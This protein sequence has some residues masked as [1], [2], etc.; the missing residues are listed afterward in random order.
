MYAIPGD[1]DGFTLRLSAID[2]SGPMARGVAA[3]LALLTAYGLWSAPGVLSQ[4]GPVGVTGIAIA[5]LWVLAASLALIIARVRLRWSGLAA[6]TVLVVALRLYPL[7][8]VEGRVPDGDAAIYPALAQS[9]LAGHGLGVIDPSLEVRVWAYYPP[10]FP[11][12]LAGW[13]AIAGFSARS[14]LVFNLIVDTVAALMILRIAERLGMARAGRAAAWLYLIWPSVL[15]SAP[16]AQKEGLSIVLFLALVLAW[17]AARDGRGVMAKGTAI[18]VLTAALAL[19]QPGFA[20]LSALIGLACLPQMGLRRA[21][22]VG[23][24]AAPVAVL[25]ML[26]WWIR[27]ALLFHAFVPLTTASGVSLW[28]GNNPDATGNWLPTP[29]NIWHA[30]EIEYARITGNM[31][32]G[33]IEAHPVEFVR[34][35]VTKFVRSLGVDHFGVVRLT[36]LHPDLDEETL[37]P[38]VPVE[39]LAYLALLAGAAVA[40]WRRVTRPPALL[41]ALIVAAFAQML[42]FGVWFEFGERHRIFLLP[43]LLLTVAMLIVPARD[44][45]ALAA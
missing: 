1:S 36:A 26:Q 6:L 38:L 45:P 35:T 5:I 2:L 30:G 4:F 28:V 3:L 32:R 31:A 41:I 12:L 19:T 42:M 27:N 22:R 33:W 39:A 21:I 23:V 44:R 11:V 25:V 37:A 20:P 34:L 7:M 8:L 24:V 43:L 17:M 14:Y 16:Y 15:L 18:G 9:L 40:L 10:G 13:G 29:P